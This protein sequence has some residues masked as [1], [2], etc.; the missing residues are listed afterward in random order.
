MERF[1]LDAAH[2]MWN[3]EG[4]F[5]WTPADEEGVAEEDDAL[6]ND[7]YSRIDFDKWAFHLSEY[8]STG[9]DFGSQHETQ[10]PSDFHSTSDFASP[11]CADTSK[12][13]L[14]TGIW[15]LPVCDIGF[16]PDINIQFLA[17]SPPLPLKV[18]QPFSF[19]RQ[20]RAESVAEY[21]GYVPV[22]TLWGCF[23]QASLPQN[24]F[25]V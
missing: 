21:C 17:Y 19:Q 25:L 22:E 2:S 20:S 6:L 10:N 18:P 4:R 1:I 7:D 24:F 9:E 23:A 15:S 14:E 3:K 11:S 13:R 8:Y 16:P 5:V 12:A